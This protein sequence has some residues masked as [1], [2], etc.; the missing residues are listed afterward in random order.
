MDRNRV[1]LMGLFLLLVAVDCSLDDTKVDVTAKSRLDS[2][3]NSTIGSNVESDLVQNSTGV[4]IVKGNEKHQLDGSKE[5]MEN[6]TNKTNLDDQ[7]AAKEADHVQKREIDL[8]NQSK[9]QH[10][11]KKGKPGDIVE[12]KEGTKEKGHEVKTKFRTPSRKEGARGEECDPS[13]MCTDEKDK[14]VACLRVPGNESPDLSLLIQNKGK[15]PLNIKISA[16]DFVRLEKTEVQLQEKEDRKVK[17]SIKD[18]GTGNL[19]VL[20]AGEGH[21]GLDFKDLIS[22]NLAKESHTSTQSTYIIH[23]SRIPVIA[24][25][26]F[27]SLLILASAWMYMTFRRRQVSSNVGKYQRLDME[28]PDCGGTKADSDTNDGWNDSWG[29]SWDDEEAPKA[30]TTPV[31]P[32]LSSKGLASRRLNKEGWKD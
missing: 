27:A 4:D 6:A 17:V 10:D 13:N 19:I 28:F 21:C 15:S 18:G 12:Q 20:T 25:V 24:F 16:P 1:L 22:R 30:P 5:G 9:G 7:P 3:I 31:T 23:Q 26:I 29:D 32:S 11:E 2:N 14:F 8:S